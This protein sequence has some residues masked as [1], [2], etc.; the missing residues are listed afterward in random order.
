MSKPDGN[1]VN[2]SVAYGLITALQTGNPFR[3]SLTAT[4]IHPMMAAAQNIVNHVSPTV[5]QMGNGVW[6]LGRTEFVRT[7]T[8]EKTFTCWGDAKEGTNAQNK[9]LQKSIM[10]YISEKNLLSQSDYADLKLMPLGKEASSGSRWNRQFGTTAKHLE[11]YNVYTSLSSDEWLEI[12][13]E[14]RLKVRDSENS[15][16]NEEEEG[17]DKHSIVFELRCSAADGKG[18]INDFIEKAF[19]W[20]TELQESQLDKARYM[21]IM[22]SSKSSEEEEEEEDKGGARYKRYKLVGNKT[23]NSL[24][25]PDKSS[26]MRLLDQFMNREGKFAI[27]GFPHKLGLL[28]YGPPGTGKTS[29]IKALAQYTGRSIVNVP[30]GRIKT[31]QELMD[32]MFDLKFNVAGQDMPIQMGFSKLIFVLEDV[33][34]ATSVV[35]KRA[36]GESGK[37]NTVDDDNEYEEEGVDSVDMMKHMLNE[38]MMMQAMKS[39]TSMSDP[40]MKGS[41]GMKSFE[42]DKTD[43]LDLSGVLNVL[44]GVVDCPERIL[45]MTTNHPEKL[46]P[47][48]IRPGRI[49]LKLHL[50]YMQAPEMLQMLAHY[51]GELT[52]AQHSSAKAA[53]LEATTHGVQFTPA[54]LEQLCAEADQVEDFVSSVDSSYQVDL[55]SIG[56]E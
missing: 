13:P 46:D 25:L 2:S 47:A 8:Y 49:N 6:R 43:A 44:D 26:L 12:E 4:I 39:S 38:M 56:E 28:L 24:F 35:H 11:Q 1:D 42:L 51:F 32:C 52:P 27:P 15:P 36:S 20:Y 50:N 18:R 7:I 31:N 34:A 14:L 37:D 9:I 5:K 10:L 54:Q 40:L 33:D 3:D 16:E 48:L 55:E 41:G 23:F 21:Y 17:G 22:Q 53:F 45:V 19:A 29:M 30:L